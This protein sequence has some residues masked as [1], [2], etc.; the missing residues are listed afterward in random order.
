MGTVSHSSEDG[1]LGFRPPLKR[2][3]CR[4]AS[5]V[6]G[7]VLADAVRESLHRARRRDVMFALT[8]DQLERGDKLR[9]KA[10]AEYRRVSSPL[11]RV[12]PSSA[13][14][15]TSTK[16]PGFTARRTCSIYCSRSASDVRK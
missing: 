2:T 6:A 10:S 16:P 7:Q 15:A 12:G 11:Q 5:V 4:T 8:R 13:K 9:G 3:L 14:V 1:A